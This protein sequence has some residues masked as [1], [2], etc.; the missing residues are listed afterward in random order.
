MTSMSED[1]FSLPNLWLLSGPCTLA[2]WP[3]SLQNLCVCKAGFFCGGR[4]LKTWQS[5]L[6]LSSSELEKSGNI[7]LDLLAAGT[8]V[9]HSI[10]HESI[11]KAQI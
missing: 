4:Q 2:L 1:S 6:S 10:Y 3:G 11:Y 7:S 5:S 8:A 9:D